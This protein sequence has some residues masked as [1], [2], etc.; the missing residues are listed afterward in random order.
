MNRNTNLQRAA[1]ALT[2]FTAVGLTG[3]LADRWIGVE[4]G[5][6]VVA[7]R[8]GTATISASAGI[9]TLEIDRDKRLA[10][11]TLVDGS[12]SIVPFVPRDKAAWPSGCPTN[13]NSTRMEVLDL[14]DKL[15]TIGSLT[16]RQPVL[17]RDCPPGPMQ[18]LLRDALVA[19]VIGGGGAACAHLDRCIFF[20]RRSTDDLH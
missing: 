10:I 19:G 16:L 5:E 11:F 17:V 15:L 3:C 8:I 14:T 12:E 13:I 20:E 18:V 1:I 7:N 9:R 6:Y 4:P 2:I